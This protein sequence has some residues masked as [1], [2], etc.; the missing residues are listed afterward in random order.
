MCFGCYEEYGQPRIINDAVISAAKLVAD[1]YD[2]NFVG[3]NLHIVLDDWNIEDDHLGWCAERIAQNP[4]KDEP[5]Q[6]RA[7]EACCAAFMALSLEE[8]AT[9][10]ALHDEY[11][12]A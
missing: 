8:R 7:E 3:G 5:E 2:F 11:I 10:L 4:D 6:I 12:T 9:A 1:V